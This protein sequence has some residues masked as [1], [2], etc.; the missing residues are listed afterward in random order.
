M[1]W[2]DSKW[3]VNEH[4]ADLTLA[5]KLCCKKKNPR[6]SGRRE[7]TVEDDIWMEESH[8]LA[9]PKGEV[10]EEPAKVDRRRLRSREKNCNELRYWG[11]NLHQIQGE[12]VYLSLR[13][14][15]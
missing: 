9:M 1:P 12:R 6:V 15:D 5:V 10:I 14:K 8:Y 3:N 7:R 11:T 2:K 13:T 4:Y